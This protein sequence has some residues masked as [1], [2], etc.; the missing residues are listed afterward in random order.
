MLHFPPRE[1]CGRIPHSLFAALPAAADS[2]VIY[3]NSN[4]ALGTG[5]KA[6]HE[7]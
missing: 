1:F 4:R 2:E 5:I 3:G 6:G 7:L